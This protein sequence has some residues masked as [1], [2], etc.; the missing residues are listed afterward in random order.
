MT[1]LD[2][3][4]DRNATQPHFLNKWVL[5]FVDLAA[6]FASWS[7]DPSTK[8]GC[9]LT[10]GK[11]GI[12][13]YGYNGFAPGVSDDPALYADREKKYRRVVHSEPNAILAARGRKV[14]TCYTWPFPP[15]S[16]CAA[17]LI[18]AGVEAVVAPLPTPELRERWRDSLTDA[19]EQ[20]DDAGVDVVLVDG[21]TAPVVTVRPDQPEGL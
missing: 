12:V 4:L 9:V 16:Q 20:F 1:H 18:R 19:A 5:R 15:C 21:Y 3:W 13:G 11:H 10:R 14:D 2:A 6:H 8:C 17:L 7:K